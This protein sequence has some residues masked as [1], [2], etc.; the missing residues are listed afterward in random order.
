M[1]KGWNCQSKSPIGPQKWCR[2]SERRLDQGTP[3]RET[4]S[5]KESSWYARVIWLKYNRQRWYRARRS[6]KVG[7]SS[8]LWVCSFNLCRLHDSLFF[9]VWTSTISICTYTYSEFDWLVKYG[10]PC[11]VTYWYGSRLKKRQ[12]ATCKEC[13]YSH[14]AFQSGTSRRV[15]PQCKWGVQLPQDV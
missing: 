13:L 15:S 2:V 14:M 7:L 12:D 10:T 11:F 8:V 4:W 6:A 5:G 3:K 9:D 1:A